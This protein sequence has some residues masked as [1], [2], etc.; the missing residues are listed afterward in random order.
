M[1][2]ESTELGAVI[3][4]PR[5]FGEYTYVRT[6]GSAASSVVLLVVD[7]TGCPYAAKVV[8][9]ELLIANSHLEYFEREIRLLQIIR[10]PNIVRLHEILYQ[11]DNIVV[12]ME[13]CEHGDLFEHLARHGALPFSQLRFFI[14]PLLNAL[15]HLHEK[16]FAHRDVKPETILVCAARWSRSRTSGSRGRSRAT[17]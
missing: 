13:F 6:I 8:K 9:R 15:Q 17:G 4:I 14:Y 7:R 12:V 16:G 2:V 10:H 11:T 3:E 1:I 5:Q